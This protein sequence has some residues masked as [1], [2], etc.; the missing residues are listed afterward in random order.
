MIVSLRCE[1]KLFFRQVLLAALTKEN[2]STF[3]EPLASE[4]LY[5]K[6]A[7][8]RLVAWQRR[9]FL[10]P[11]FLRR[12][13]C[14]SPGYKMIWVLFISFAVSVVYLLSHRSSNSL[15]KADANLTNF[16]ESDKYVWLLF[17]R[18]PMTDFTQWNI[19]TGIVLLFLCSFYSIVYR[20]PS[21]K[22][23]EIANIASHHPPSHPRP[24]LASHAN[25]LRGSSRVPT[26]RTWGRKDCVTNP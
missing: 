18:P 6:S 8:T 7:T 12:G 19:A 20:L 13:N 17:Y 21:L 23:W 14:L 22:P 16:P 25:V 11:Y 3:L 5:A 24:T 26:P 15:L 9:M 4:P 1:P 10:L 2:V